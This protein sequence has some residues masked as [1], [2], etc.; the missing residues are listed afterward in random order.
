MVANKKV[1]N[2]TPSVATEVRATGLRNLAEQLGV[3]VGF[4]RLEISRG[5]LLPTRLGR[6][7]VVTADEARRY[8]AKNQAAPL[9][10][11]ARS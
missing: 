1:Q 11:Q 8:L 5:R 4:L 2:L 3:S 7:V 6:R 9:P 10:A